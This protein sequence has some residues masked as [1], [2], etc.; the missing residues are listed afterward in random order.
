VNNIKSAY[1]NET[2]AY[3]NHGYDQS[4]D[5]DG[6][7]ERYNQIT[8]EPVK[9][10]EQRKSQDI[11]SFLKNKPLWRLL[12]IWFCGAFNFVNVL[13]V[14]PIYTEDELDMSKA[15]GSMLIMII[16]V[17]EIFSKLGIG[18]LSDKPGFKRK[19]FLIVNFGLASVATFA[20]T[21]LDDYL[22]LVIF[23]VIIGAL[24]SNFPTFASVMLVDRV[25][26]EN[27][28][29]ASGMVMCVASFAAASGPP[30]ISMYQLYSIENIPAVLSLPIPYEII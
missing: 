12:V 23:G 18:Y 8:H 9:I 25:G 7:V 27:I 11:Y 21:L 2:Y 22:S 14:L 6:D 13:V 3:Q 4:H 5:S 16:G 28:G 10:V 24:G 29:K 1:D 20:V 30:L 26:V 19:Q 15:K 17:V